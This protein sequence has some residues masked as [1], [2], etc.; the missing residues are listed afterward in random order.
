M[1]CSYPKYWERRAWDNSAVPDQM[2]QNVPSDQGLYCLLLIHQFLD[3]LIGS[4]IEIKSQDK[5]G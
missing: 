5:Y 4:K 2:P 1:C 3:T